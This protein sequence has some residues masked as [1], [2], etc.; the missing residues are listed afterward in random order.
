MEYS[1]LSPRSHEIRVLTILSNH[2]SKA[3]PIHCS[4][5][6]VGL[7]P[8]STAK[9]S[10]EINHKFHDWPPS[11]VQTDELNALWRDPAHNSVWA[12]APIGS[13]QASISGPSNNGAPSSRFPWGDYVALSYVWG[14]PAVTRGI[15]VNGISVQVTENL[16]EALRELREYD[17]IKQG[18]KVW[19]DAI[20]INQNDIE[21]RA[22]QVGIMKHIYASAW[23]VV[24]WLGKESDDSNLAMTAVR[25]L[26]LRA[27]DEKLPDDLYHRRRT[28]D[29]RPLFIVW[30]TYKSYLKIEVYR[31]LYRVFSRQYW[32]RLWILQEIA[33]SRP[34]TPVLCGIK[35]V[36][37]QDIYTACVFTQS[38]EH[39]FGRE[40][41]ESINPR[42]GAW[43]WEFGRD[44][45]APRDG[46]RSFSER[47][48]KKPISMMA[49]QE[50]Q[51]QHAAES[52]ESLAAFRIFTLSRDA[53][54]TDERDRVYGIL[55]IA[56]VSNMVSITPDYNLSSNEVFRTFSQAL[57]S[58]GDLSS[59]C[60]VSSRIPKIN[61]AWPEDRTS[62]LLK[63]IVLGR[64]GFIVNPPCPHA[65][66]SWV[67]CWTCSRGPIAQLPGRYKAAGTSRATPE[68]LDPGIVR[69]QG[70]FLGSVS[71]LSAFHPL[72]SDSRY[73]ENGNPS[74]NNKYGDIIFV[75]KA[76]LQT[77]LAGT[78]RTGD[79]ISPVSDSL[80]SN[81]KIWIDAV[82]GIQFNGFGL[83]G[84][85]ARN[86]NLSLFGYTLKDVLGRPSRSSGRLYN[87]SEAQREVLSWAVDALAWRRL[88]TTRSGY[89]G[90]APAGTRRGDCVWMLMGCYMPLILRPC[91]ERWE[92]VGECYVNGVMQ[93][94]VLDLVESGEYQVRD[95]ELC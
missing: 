23:K 59:L 12:L 76:L 87:P 42:I 11:V 77:L 82:A 62:P 93:G 15:F 68:F 14:N 70:V 54:V 43:T 49:I 16:E 58:T 39:R 45:V 52:D 38:E 44:R 94:E 60:L 13:E 26:S 75:R 86:K 35:C 81:P 80:I 64:S 72:E 46:S 17:C 19:I 3:D 5:E 65:L 40:I 61:R 24:V 67:I 1:P 74:P 85:Y 18:F 9:S 90:I 6:H 51:Q 20:C 25:Y 88:I 7:L 53:N 92:V 89:M 8:H 4:L 33:L 57:L 2:F 27:G 31:A 37:W 83:H 22:Q 66:P 48:W 41:I 95:V 84:F 10:A 78:S 55:G 56:A 47:L 36:H 34:D 29:L 71:S 79:P 91:K 69:V 50:Q 28:V 73:P 30:S 63:H 32:Q 21:E